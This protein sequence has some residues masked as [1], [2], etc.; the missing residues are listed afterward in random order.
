[1]LDYS[2]NMK[3]LIEDISRRCAVFK[4]IDSTAI[5]VGISRSRNK[6]K[7]GLQAKLVPMK[8]QG[9]LQVTQIDKHG[10]EMPKMTHEGNEILYL[11]YFCLPRFQNLSFQAK[12]TTIFHELYHIDPS[13]NGDIRRFPGRFYQH[14]HSEKEYD[15]TVQELSRSYLSNPFS[16]DHTHFLRFRYDELRRHYGEITGLKLYVPEP[17]LLRPKQGMLF[18]SNPG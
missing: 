5:L 12:M 6:R 2:L 15:R 18:E 3:K 11:I 4:Y 14:S 13:F 16:K 1:M 17:V 8:F 9:G 7:D 10:Y